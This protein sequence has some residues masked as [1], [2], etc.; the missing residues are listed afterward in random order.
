MLT[1]NKQ[2]QNGRR[3]RNRHLYNEFKDAFGVGFTPNETAK[4]EVVEWN[5][6]R[7]ESI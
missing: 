1:K 2:H 6:Q 4:K 7:I 5:R 3:F